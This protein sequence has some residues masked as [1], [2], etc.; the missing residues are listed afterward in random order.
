MI[1]AM[2]ETRVVT[3]DTSVFD[4]RNACIA[5]M[6]GNFNAILWVDTVQ[7]AAVDRYLN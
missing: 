6:P 3:R 4:E 1:L 5:G 2:V 7:P